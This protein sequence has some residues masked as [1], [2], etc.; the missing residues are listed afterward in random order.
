MAAG[1]SV[2]WGWQCVWRAG[3]AGVPYMAAFMAAL[4]DIV[5][6]EARQKAPR[7]LDRKQWAKQAGGGPPPFFLVSPHAAK[8]FAKGCF[9]PL[10][11]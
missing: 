9:L 6:Q 3:S 10:Q 1:R 5:L 7:G 11:P 8:F 4:P 2:S